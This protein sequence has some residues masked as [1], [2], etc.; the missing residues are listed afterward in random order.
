MMPH[1][2]WSEIQ[3]GNPKFPGA[4]FLKSCD[5]IVDDPNKLPLYMNDLINH[6]KIRMDDHSCIAL[7]YDKSFHSDILDNIA[8][9]LSSYEISGKST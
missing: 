6:L 3:K 8:K 9:N 1:E 7:K 4:V 2:R 5:G